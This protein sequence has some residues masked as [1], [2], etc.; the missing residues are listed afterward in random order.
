M[1]ENCKGG[2]SVY[3]LQVHILWSTKY[4]Y[5][6]LRGDIQLRCRDLIRQVYDSMDIRIMKGLVSK[7]HVHQH[8]S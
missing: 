2:H 8:L 3:E 1:K 7:D 5:G 6:V 4:K